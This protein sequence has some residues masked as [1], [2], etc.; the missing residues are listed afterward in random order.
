[1]DQSSPIVQV[2]LV[3]KTIAS[4]PG[5]FPSFCHILY[6]TKAGKEPGNEG[7]EPGTN[8]RKMV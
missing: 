1:M 4:F 7:E 5:S 2:F 6:V 8:A 3:Q